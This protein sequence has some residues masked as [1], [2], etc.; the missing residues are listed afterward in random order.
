MPPG[1]TYTPI[2]YSFPTF[3]PSS[4]STPNG[5]LAQYVG[6]SQLGFTA[7]S[8]GAYDI[9]VE[10]NAIAKLVSSGD[11]GAN[12]TNT[13]Y[14]IIWRY[15]TS[16]STATAWTVVNNQNLLYSGSGTVL[17]APYEYPLVNGIVSA[18]TTSTNSN[19][20]IAV[21]FGFY[22][23]NVVGSNPVYNVIYNSSLSIRQILPVSV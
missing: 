22:G 2:Y 23:G 14:F 15:L 1:V 7:S 8:Y 18:I 20:Q 11:S 5:T 10:F 3:G 6:I 16:G 4:L 9:Y 17:N 21:V 13:G 12:S 19:V